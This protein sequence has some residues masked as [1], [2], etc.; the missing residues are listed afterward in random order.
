MF[1]ILF[2]FTPLKLSAF[3]EFSSASKADCNAIPRAWS[4]KNVLSLST[5]GLN[6]LKLHREG[7]CLGLMWVWFCLCMFQHL[8]MQ[9]NFPEICDSRVRMT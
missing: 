2:L 4:F 3:M 7:H 9:N 8:L 1:F 6:S 5:D